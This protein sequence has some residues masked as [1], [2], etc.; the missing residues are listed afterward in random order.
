M[1]ITAAETRQLTGASWKAVREYE[2]ITFEID[3]EGIAK[4]TICRPHVRN[5]FP[6]G[7]PPPS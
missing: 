2:D 3:G 6:A 4:I 5:A 1:T 7:K